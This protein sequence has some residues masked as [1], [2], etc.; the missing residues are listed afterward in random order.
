[1]MDH[2]AKNTFA[3]REIKKIIENH[4]DKIDFVA[5]ERKAMDEIKRIIEE[6]YMWDNKASEYEEKQ[7]NQKFENEMKILFKRN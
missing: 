1:M 7:S 4:E 2:K 6:V 5:E 3:L